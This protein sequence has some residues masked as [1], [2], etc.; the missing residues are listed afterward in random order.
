MSEVVAGVALTHPDRILFPEQG[1]TKGELARYHTAVASRIL[2]ELAGR[3]LTLVRC[4]QGRRKACFV[5]RHPGPGT[6]EA[7][8]RVR[9]PGEEKPYLALH[10][11]AGLVALV[12]IGTLE[13][14]P[15][16][17]RAEAPER[18]DRLI[19]D[20]DPGEGTPFAAVVAAALAARDLLAGLSLASFV[21]T[22]GGR[23][24][25]VVAPLAAD[26]GWEAHEVA[27]KALAERLAA[28]DPGRLTTAMRKAERGS[29]I[30][31]DWLRNARGASAVAPL[32]PRA[33]AGATVAMPLAWD[34]LGSDLDPAAFTIRTVPALLA[35]RPDPW[36]GIADLRQKLPRG[37]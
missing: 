15:W 11:L 14:H 16:P 10:D 21:K 29:R 5:Q 6:P 4:P 13:L 34:E 9:V 20:L 22:T 18:P 32:S 24:L 17:A 25:H 26:H 28:G 31:V 1:V 27:A 33:R 36:A 23:G 7:L 35:D 37:L 3:P 12:Q 19:L 2:P 8:K 30:F